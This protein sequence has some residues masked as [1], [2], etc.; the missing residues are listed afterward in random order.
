[1]GDSGEQAE[2]PRIA[3]VLTGRRNRYVYTLGVPSQGPK[4][5]RLRRV[6]K[7]DVELGISESFE[8]RAIGR[9]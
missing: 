4:V 9:G 6:V 2:F 3:P 5:L 1:M 8:H 7:R